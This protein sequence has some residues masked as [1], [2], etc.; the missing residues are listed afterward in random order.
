MGTGRGG[1]CG[2]GERRERALT[3]IGAGRGG[4]GVEIGAAD[5]GGGCLCWLASPV[6]WLGF[7]FRFLVGGEEGGRRRRPRG[8][9]QPRACVHYTER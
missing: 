1:G 4:G 2:S 9:G 3:G 6:D 5:P 8:R 7:W